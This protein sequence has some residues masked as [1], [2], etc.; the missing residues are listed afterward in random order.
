MEHSEPGTALEV[1]KLLNKRES[2]GDH[3]LGGDERGGDSEDEQD[4]VYG[5]ANTT[6]NGEV[7]DGG[8]N[9]VAMNTE[10][11]S[12]SKIGEEKVD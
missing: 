2:R 4:P 11:G 7:E 1:D 8:D 6:R 12:L 9:F 5:A 10:L 3:G